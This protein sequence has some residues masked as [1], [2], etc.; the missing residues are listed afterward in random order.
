MNARMAD[1]LNQ[2]PEE[3]RHRYEQQWLDEQGRYRALFNQMTEGIILL[4]D[5]RVVDCN[6]AALAM[7]GAK[8]RADLLGKA[9]FQF[10]PARQPDGRSSKVYSEELI[11]RALAG[12]SPRFTW[13]HTS[14]EGREIDTDISLSTYAFQGRSFVQ[15]VLRDITEQ[16]RLEEETARLQEDFH[17]AQ[18][19]EIVGQLAGG[20]AH[21]F[22]NLLQAVISHAEMARSTPDDRAALDGHL[23]QIEAAAARASQLTSQ[24][25]SFGRRQ[26]LLKMNLDF[27]QVVENTLSIARPI[28][29]ENMDVVQEISDELLCV[30]ADHGQIEQSL[31]NII[32][33]ARDAMKNGGRM[34]ARLFSAD[35]AHPLLEKHAGPVMENGYVVFQLEDTGEG[36][37]ADILDKVTEPFFTTKPP[38]KG[39]GLGL[40]SVTGIVGQHGGFLDIRSQP[41]QGTTVTIFLPRSDVAGAC[42]PNTPDREKLAD[43]AGEGEAGPGLALRILVVDDNE[44]IRNATARM[45]EGRGCR[46]ETAEDGARAVE[47]VRRAADPFD[48]IIMDRV[49]P[50][51]GGAEALRI[52]RTDHPQLPCLFIS[53]HDE[54]GAEDLAGDPHAAFLPKP[55]RIADLLEK[56]A[57]LTPTRA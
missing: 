42:C 57:D 28:L 7:L 43:T 52:I 45:L 53:G 12:E 30:L 4:E 54:S 41:G 49:M 23:E 20:I 36:I 48:L 13:K 8:K 40:A 29:P 35:V 6:P 14:A 31:L 51:M 46:V 17:R 32:L 38:G 50:E 55:F 56:V 34:T 1:T 16:K 11:R 25:L 22:N 10:S 27:R 15:A 3:D 18:R 37:P 5:G 33:N 24:M 26:P 19:M 9:P 21:N 44:M 2:P 39:S 47:A